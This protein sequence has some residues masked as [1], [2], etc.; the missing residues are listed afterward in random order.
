MILDDEA[1][2][3]AGFLLQGVLKNEGLDVPAHAAG[4]RQLLVFAHGGNAFWRGLDHPLSAGDPLDEAS[5]ACA[6][7]FM[8]R[9]GVSDYEILYP[10]DHFSVNLLEVGRRLGWQGDSKMSIGI[11]PEFG[12]WFAYR[13]VIAANTTFEQT[14]KAIE[15]PCDTCPTKPCVAACPAGAVRETGF[16]LEVCMEERTRSGSN[17]AYQCLARLACPVGAEHQYQKSQIN[18]HYGRSL[19]SLHRYQESRK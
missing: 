15:Q 6:R 14:T 16:D 1:L 17:C 10:K 3:Q 7:S 9:M 13:M 11:H 2:R 12:T 18:Y 4:Y 19:V 5:T 8:Q